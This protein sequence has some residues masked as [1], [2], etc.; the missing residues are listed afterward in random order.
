VSALTGSV[1][2]LKGPLGKHPCIQLLTVAELLEGKG[3]DYPRTA[4]VNVTLKAAP[5]ADV[6]DADELHLFSDAQLP[7]KAG[8]KA[9]KKKGRR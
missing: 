9:K 8:P 1:T 5:R 2:T 7:L 6:K 4:G 3:I